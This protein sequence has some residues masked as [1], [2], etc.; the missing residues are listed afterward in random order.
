MITSTAQPF[1]CCNPQVASCDQ[2]G[3]VRITWQVQLADAWVSHQNTTSRCYPVCDIPPC[4]APTSAPGGGGTASIGATG[5]TATSLPSVEPCFAAGYTITANN[6]W[7]MQ[8]QSL[9]FTFKSSGFVDSASVS[10]IYSNDNGA[11]TLTTCLLCRG[12]SRVDTYDDYVTTCWSSAGAGNSQTLTSCNIG[13]TTPTASCGCNL[14]AVRYYNRAYYLSSPAP[15]TIKAQTTGASSARYYSVELVGAVRTF[16]LWNAANTNIYSLDISG[17]TLEQAR[18]TLDAQ[19][20]IVCA[21]LMAGTGAAQVATRALTANLIAARG[22]VP[23]PTTSQT[24]ISVDLFAPGLKTEWWQAEAMCPL[25]SVSTGG[26]VIRYDSQPNLAFSEGYGDAAEAMFCMGY[27]TI[28]EVNTEGATP[29]WWNYILSQFEFPLSGG[30]GSLG[31]GAYAPSPQNNLSCLVRTFTA[32]TSVALTR[33]VFGSWGTRSVPLGSGTSTPITS[34][35]LGESSFSAVANGFACDF[36]TGCE[37]ICCPN[38]DPY[39]VGLSSGCAIS[40]VG[41]SWI[42]QGMFRL[43]RIV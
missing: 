26:A 20:T 16:K 42:T 39:L 14:I 24:A 15:F 18:S 7:V 21:S 34:G 23:I 2:T 30:D 10:W 6:S 31:Y 12:R 8:P 17:L 38:E 22:F 41:T 4:S 29:N 43:E 32:G 3:K 33:C 37:D 40:Y 35:M 5:Y 19:A 28:V 36:S 9:D 1:C 27:E 13:N 11:T 25:W